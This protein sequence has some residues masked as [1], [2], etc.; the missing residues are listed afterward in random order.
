MKTLSRERVSIEVFKILAG[1]TARET[2]EVMVSH[3]VLAALPDAAY[4]PELLQYLCRFQKDFGLVAVPPRLYVLG[5]CRMEGV[6]ALAEFL[7]I[8]RVFTRDM[9]ALHRVMA[10]PDLSADAPVRASVYQYGRSA[11]AQGLMLQLALD[12]VM[13]RY[14]PQ[15][16]KIIQQWP[17]PDFPVSGLDLQARGMAA[18]PGLGETLRRLENWWI[19]QDF[20]PGKAEILA[21]L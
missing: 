10:L 12:R 13:T 1:D 7:L 3:G 14:A 19:A 16:L 9:E 11:S 8:P 5:G 4:R 21:Q 6:A 17:V 20:K 2:L 18:G 15:A